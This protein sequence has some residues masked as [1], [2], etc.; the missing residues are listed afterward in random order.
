MFKFKSLIIVVACVVALALVTSAHAD[1]VTVYNTPDKGV[2]YG[3]Q[4]DW[5]STAAG[6][7]QSGTSKEVGEA[8][9][10]GV[11]MLGGQV[12]SGTSSAASGTTPTPLYDV[13]VL[14]FVGLDILNGA[15]ANLATGVTDPSLHKTP[16]N[17]DGSYIYLPKGT[18]VAPY[19]TNAGNAKKGTIYLW[20]RR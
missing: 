2:T 12:L 6:A 9:L 19:V 7:Y 10:V 11:L 15:G 4:W 17:N 13:Q 16:F 20:L 18:R 3:V 5:T 8:W 14:D 1:G